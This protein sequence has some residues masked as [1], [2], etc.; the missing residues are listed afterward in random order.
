VP[1]AGD[2]QLVPGSVNGRGGT[3]TGS[4]ASAEAPSIA[5]IQKQLD[6]DGNDDD[7]QRWAKPA[8]S[9]SKQHSLKPEVVDSRLEK[10]PSQNNVY[11]SLLLV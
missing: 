6:D 11:C 8:Y 9:N 3:G 10:C 4:T 7:Q 1:F 2:Q 5:G